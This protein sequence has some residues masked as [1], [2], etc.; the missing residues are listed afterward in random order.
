[1]SD[2][3]NILVQYNEKPTTSPS[4]MYFNLLIPIAYAKHIYTFDKLLSDFY[5]RALRISRYYN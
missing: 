3:S 4:W 1:M 2:E 5:P